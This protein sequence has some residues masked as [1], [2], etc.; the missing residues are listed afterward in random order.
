[1]IPK[2]V[3]NARIRKATRDCPTPILE[4]MECIEKAINDFGDDLSVSCS[5]GSCSVVV[6]HMAL[7]LD[8]NIKVIFNNTGV[9]YPETYRYRDLLEEKWSL[10]LIETKPVKSFW[11]CVRKW[12]LPNIRVR[13]ETQKRRG[14]TYSTGRPPCCRYLKELPWAHACR[15]HNIKASLT[16]LRAAESRMRMFNF[17]DR[18]QYYYT[19]TYKIWKFNPVAFW[20]H[21]QVWQYLKDHDLPVNE[22]YTKLGLERSGCMPCTGYKGWSEILA[23]VN[24]KLY[25]HIQRLRG[26]SLISDFLELENQAV[27]SCSRRSI[28]PVLEEWF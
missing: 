15:E 3:E 28:Q 16:G 2:A 25:R 20:T 27:D 5:F 19:K 12:G 9:D 10:N 24:P 17:S 4:P 14:Y 13:R 11:E 23:R 22:V 8:P 26:V 18:G 21:A 7:S 6:L 1:M